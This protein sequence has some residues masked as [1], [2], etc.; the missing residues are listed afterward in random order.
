MRKRHEVKDAAESFGIELGALLTESRNCHAEFGIIKEID[1]LCRQRS[2]SHLDDK[3]DEDLGRKL[4][5]SGKVSNG[6]RRITGNIIDN[7]LN[8]GIE[9][10][11]DGA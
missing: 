3:R 6:I 5:V 1:K 7:G 8:S 2:G 11:P 4:A 9:L 10:T